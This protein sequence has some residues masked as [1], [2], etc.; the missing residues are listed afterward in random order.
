MARAM[1]ATL[2]GL[3]ATMAARATAGT[4]V[5]S[6]ISQPPSQRP[7]TMVRT[8]TGESQVKWN[9]PPRIS[10]PSTAS[11]ITRHPIGMSSENS[12]T[13]ATTAKARAGG[14]SLV[15]ESSPN[16]TAPTQ[17]RASVHQRLAGRQARSV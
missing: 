1:A 14:S 11:P 3:R 7:A 5:T 17:G 4:S 2:P 15:S 12:P 10:A 6:A 9:V 16:I 8:G 13:S